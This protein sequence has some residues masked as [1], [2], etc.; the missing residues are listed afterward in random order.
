[1]DRLEDEVR[2]REDDREQQ[3]A[4]RDERCVGEDV[5]TERDQVDRERRVDERVVHRPAAY[6]SGRLP[7]KERSL[8]VGGV[9]RNGRHAVSLLSACEQEPLDLLLSVQIDHR[10]EQVA[11]LVLT[12]GIN[13]ERS[14]D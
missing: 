9:T 13:A 12:A 6:E 5:E 14:A 4:L 8:L 1:D 7:D 11:L 10:T 3:A 2:A